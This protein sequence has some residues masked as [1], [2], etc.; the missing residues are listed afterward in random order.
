[1]GPTR[2]TSRETTFPWG[3]TKMYALSSI[4]PNV[5]DV[6]KTPDGTKQRCLLT[7][8]VGKICRSGTA[9]LSGRKGLVSIRP[10]LL[11]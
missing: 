11:R 1:M 10:A 8:S 3:G 9:H 2:G 6:L 4:I 7:T 5:F